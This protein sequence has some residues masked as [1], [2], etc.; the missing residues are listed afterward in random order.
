MNIFCDTSALIKKYVSE[1][2]SAE[3]DAIINRADAVY[4]SAITEIETVS[5]FRR[6]LSD[7]VIDREDY[8]VLVDEFEFDCRYYSMMPF[9]EQVVKNALRAI[10]AYQ[11]KILD[12]IQLGTAIMVKDEIDC[13]V[14]CDGKLIQAASREKIKVINTNG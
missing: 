5:T 9:N 3:F 2:G 14:A 10:D 13:I 6:L 12:S 4:L 1:K 11:L 8:R 7:H